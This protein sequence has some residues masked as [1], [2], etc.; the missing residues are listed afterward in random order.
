MKIQILPSAIAD[1]AA[2]FTFYEQQSPG[3]GDRFLRT[4]IVD[5][6]ALSQSAGVDRRIF[7]SHRRLARIFPFAIYYAVEK[8]LI[9]VKAILDCRRDPSWLR[10]KL[11]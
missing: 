7:G 4:L 9:R 8:D 6:D 1:L 5:I 10:S 2:G 3:L 11:K